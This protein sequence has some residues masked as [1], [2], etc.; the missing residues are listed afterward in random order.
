[1]SRRRIMMLK[2]AIS[3]LIEQLI[4]EASDQNSETDNDEQDE[5]NQ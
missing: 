2:R 4:L 5:P 1:M 3:K